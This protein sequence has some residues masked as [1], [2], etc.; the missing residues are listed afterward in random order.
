MKILHVQ[1]VSGID[2][3]IELS[4][5]KENKDISHPKLQGLV[6]TAAVPNGTQ[7]IDL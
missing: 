6:Y 1:V 3:L 5:K 4:V 2:L 7:Q